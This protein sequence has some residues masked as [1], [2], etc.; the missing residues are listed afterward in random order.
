[1][2]C[3]VKTAT[4]DGRGLTW[5]GCPYCGHEVA[6]LDALTAWREIPG[7]LNASHG[8]RMAASLHIEDEAAGQHVDRRRRRS[9]GLN[10]RDCRS[11][12]VWR[13]CRSA[14]KN[15]V[16][17]FV[18]PEFPAVGHMEQGN[19]QRTDPT[20]ALGRWTFKNIPSSRLG[21]ATTLLR[22]NLLN[23][24]GRSMLNDRPI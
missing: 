10:W 9:F 22:P 8:G 24:S 20:V 16:P 11:A 5:E 18:W 17:L 14:E 3:T 6:T 12:Q 4:G 15:P 21:M 13:D 1:M 2:H 23:I 7:G 19:P